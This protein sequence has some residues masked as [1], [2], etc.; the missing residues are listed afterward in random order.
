MTQHDKDI[1]ERVA[2]ALFHQMEKEG[3]IRTNLSWEQTGSFH[4]NMYLK[5][6]QAAIVAMGGVRPQA[7]SQEQPVA[8]LNDV[9][10]GH[11]TDGVVVA[12]HVFMFESA[13]SASL[14]NHRPTRLFQRNQN[15]NNSTQN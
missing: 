14:T 13:M 4:K 7:T 8:L 11:N 1:I 5:Q 15:S 12:P 2:I 10:H 9:R 6:A 3:A